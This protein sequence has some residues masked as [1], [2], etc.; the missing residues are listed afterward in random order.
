[1]GG[2]VLVGGCFGMGGGGMVLGIGGL[3]GGGGSSGFCD[4]WVFLMGVDMNLGMEVFL[5]VIF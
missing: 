1:M 5:V 4:I 2:I 3:M